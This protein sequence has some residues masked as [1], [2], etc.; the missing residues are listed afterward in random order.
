[1]AVSNGAEVQIGVRPRA[2]VVA[3]QGPPGSV[4]TGLINLNYCPVSCF[5]YQ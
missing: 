1:M 2:S 4:T 3:A 5:R